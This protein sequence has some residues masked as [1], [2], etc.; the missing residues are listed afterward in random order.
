MGFW[1]TLFGAGVLFL[2]SALRGS[3]LSLSPRLLKFAVVA[4]FIF[5]VDLF[6]WHRSVL[7]CGA[8]MSTILANTQVF[9]T[10][11]VGFFLFKERLGVWFFMAAISAVGGV[12][13]LVGLATD[14]VIFTERYLD[15][16]FYGLVTA[17]AYAS[18]LIT[19]RWSSRKQPIPD[20]VVFMAWISLFSAFFLGF[21]GWVEAVPIL[22]P[23]AA[24]WI[25]LISLGLVAQALG[26]WAIAWSLARV[27]TAKAGLILLM[28]PTLAM[29]WGVL[30]FSEQ[31]ELTQALGAVITLVAIYFGGLRSNDSDRKT[32]R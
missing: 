13:L 3:R 26:W 20:I 31:F 21:S 12:A 5:F 29:V 27:V 23:D 9:I 25:Y 14:E 4:G 2:L 17:I 1:R 24:S 10:A 30:M 18:Y 19:L 7:Y 11:I 15:G 22:P 32:G 28:Q 16:V 8:G 6:V